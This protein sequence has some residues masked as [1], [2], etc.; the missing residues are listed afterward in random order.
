[1]ADTTTTNLLLTK[2]EVGASTD[3]WGGKLNTD[4]DSIDAVFA[5]A[6]NGTS[7][8]LNVGSGKT[9]SVA[10]TLVVTGSAST[11]DATAI[12]SSTPDSG[13]FTTLSA[14]GNVTLSGGTANGV[15]Y[16]NG[17]KVLTSGSALTFDGTKLGIGVASPVR[18]LDVS[19][20][21]RATTGT[22]FAEVDADSSAGVGFFGTA[23]NHPIGFK[24]NDSEVGRWTSTGLGIGTSSPGYKLDAR[25]SGTSSGAVIQVGNTGSGGFGGLGV[26]DGG[27]YPVQLWGAAL[28]FLTGS[29]VY[30]SATEKMRLDASG[31]LG[32]GT[33]SPDAKLDVVGNIQGRTASDGGLVLTTAVADA[34]SATVQ[35]KKSRGSYASPTDVVNGDSVF[36]ILSLA[37][38]GTQYRERVSI[39]SAVDGTFTSNQQPPLRLGFYTNAANGSAT[40]RM[41]ITSAGDVGIGT[42][43]PLTKLDIKFA[44]NKHAI[45]TASASY[46]NSADLVAVNDA[47]SEVALGL[48]G[49]TVQFYTGATERARITSGGDLLV[50]KTT[51]DDSSQNGLR[52]QSNGSITSTMQV[53]DN[54]D[55]SFVYYSKGASAYR[56]YVGGGGTVYATNTTIS[57]IS[58]QRLKE[59][60]QDLDVGLDKIMALKPRKFDWKA[61]KGKDIKSDRGWIAQEFEQVF[62]DMID[63]WKDE[64]PEGE[65]PY[66][67]VRADL[68]PVLVKALQDMKAII[69]SQ[70]ERITALEAK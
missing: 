19:G 45:F 9:L 31:N 53:S 69:D 49:S 57:A 8:G 35:F 54:T 4:L 62:P 22:V 26:S 29:S 63:T 16:L 67:S 20:Q 12:G 28:S 51:S 39:E 17:S 59:N 18:R 47:G 55:Y 15:T 42:S 1:M 13:A 23:S 24:L 68:I 11:I 61:G 60:I 41:R 44:T 6:G 40:E 58:D 33:S 43:S 25:L 30:G 65:E 37:Y 10:G 36:Q 56:F 46:S 48:G 21:I 70:A 64:A 32:I 2:P 50:A 34:R 66:K 38:S 5:A 7:V 27:A 3:T 52:L 14:S